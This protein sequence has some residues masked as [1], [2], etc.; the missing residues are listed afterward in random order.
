MKNSVIYTGVAVLA[1]LLVAGTVFMSSNI[2]SNIQ[3]DSDKYVVSTADVDKNTVSI[4]GV[5]NVSNV[6]VESNTTENTTVSVVADVTGDVTNPRVE[7]SIGSEIEDSTIDCSNFKVIDRNGQETV[8]VI[9]NGD[10]LSSI[11][12]R[13]GYSVD[14]LAEY[15]HIADVNLIYSDSAL[16]LPQQDEKK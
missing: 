11:S 14:E 12:G 5:N 3:A 2:M 7:E 15:N 6:P 9:Q 16:R 10:T 1:V 8:Y 4:N 13:V